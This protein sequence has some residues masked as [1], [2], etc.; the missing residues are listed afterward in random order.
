MY[1]RKCPLANVSIPY[2]SYTSA[3]VFLLKICIIMYI[4]VILCASLAKCMLH[5]VHALN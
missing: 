1:V 4:H 5:V 2:D 3:N